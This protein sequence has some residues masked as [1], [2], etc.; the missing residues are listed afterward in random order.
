VSGQRSG[1]RPQGGTRPRG[2]TGARAGGWAIGLL[3][4]AVLTATAPAARAQPA[5]AAEQDTAAKQQTLPP[6]ALPDIVI[7]GRSSATVRDGSKLFA[8]DKRTVLDREIGAPVGEKIESRTG[9]GGGRTLAAQERVLTGRQARAWLR[10]GSHTAFIGGLEYWRDLGRWRFIARAGGDGTAGPIDNSGS[11]SGFGELVFERSLSSVSQV[12]FGGGFTSGRQEEWGTG[13]PLQGIP[14]APLGAERTFSDGHYEVAGEFR[15]RRGLTLALGAGGR[16][17]GLRDRSR[18]GGTDLRP[19]SDGGWAD[20]AFDWV[21]DR[22]VLEL[23]A[24]LEGD[25]MRGVTPDVTSRLAQ[26]SLTLQARVGEASSGLLGVGVYRMDSALGRVTRVWPRAKFTAHYSERFGMFIRYR[27]RFDYLTLG[28][29][30]VV[31]PFV[32]NTFQVTPREERFNLAVGLTWILAPRLTLQF[33]VARRQYDR[34]PLWRLAPNTDFQSEGLFILDGIVDVAV[35]ET[36]L[37]LAGSPWEGFDLETGV[38][39]RQPGGGGIAVLSHIPETE[40]RARIT[41]DGPWGLIFGSDLTWLGERFGDTAGTGDRR[42]APAAD[43]GF[44]VARTFAGSLTAWL[45]LRNVFDSEIVLWESYARPGRTT[46]IGFSYA[47]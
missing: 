20:L 19:H 29:A 17:T 32:A 45:E 22:T 7:F 15:L 41:A 28:D 13:V 47:F 30:R 42:L 5:T 35:N 31:N 38:I 1:T 4:A 34:L 43:L 26:A 23:D 11:S 33:E 12:R 9:W 14:R 36:R 27:P 25:R 46:A 40:F 10:G 39:L 21:T 8:S 18:I 3:A 6:L 44:R 24:R 16:H 37:D 2:G